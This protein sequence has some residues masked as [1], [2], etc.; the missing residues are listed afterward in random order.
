MVK[1]IV[2]SLFFC[3]CL[4]NKA[5]AQNMFMDFQV[6]SATEPKLQFSWLSP[7]SNNMDLYTPSNN[8]LMGI[9][10]QVYKNFYLRSEFGIKTVNR[11]IDITFPAD[12]VNGYVGDIKWYGWYENTRLCLSFMPEV[13]FLSN[14]V[15]ANTGVIVCRDLVNGFTNGYEHSN[16]SYTNFSEIDAITN[17][18]TGFTFNFGINPT[19]NNV[20]VTLGFGY[21]KLSP[22]G[23]SNGVPKI[24]CSYSQ[25]N[26][27]VS[28]KLR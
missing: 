13:R 20:G 22:V 8:F 11:F 23:I 19:F 16:G 15:F 21:T 24:G 27:G 7:I 9:S 2:Y 28:Y 5:K 26:I 1:K 12:P 25:G 14:I 17:N 4:L 18:S 6:N 10:G 3:F